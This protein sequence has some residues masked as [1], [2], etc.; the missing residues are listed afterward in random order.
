VGNISDIIIVRQKET[1]N[2][3]T[4]LINGNINEAR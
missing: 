4:L 3:V 2:I 1:V